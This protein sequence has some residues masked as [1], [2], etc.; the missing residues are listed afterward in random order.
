MVTDGILVV[1]K[2][3]GPTSQQVVGR[4]RRLAGTRKVGHAGTLDPMASGVLVVGIGRATR[5]LGHL[6]RTDKE[7]RATIR[8]GQA[9]STDDAEGEV[10]AAP[11]S[12]VLVADQVA[13]AL[14]DF[15][16]EISQVPSSVSAIKVGGVRAYARA[17]AGEE[18]TLAARTVTVHS[19]TLLSA[20][21]ERLDG[22]DLL[23]VDV[24]VACTSGTYIRALARDLGERFGVGAHLTALR[25]TRVGAFDLSRACLLDPAPDPLPVLGL[26]EVAAGSFERLDLTAAEA[27]EV[28]HGRRLERTIAGQVAV[29]S[30]EGQFLA[31]YRPSDRGAVAEAVFR[32]A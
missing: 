11:G 17:R 5:L 29:F 18:V 4:V 16:G 14:P 7:Y 6:M 24:D 2:T 32:P 10:L 28:R 31:L 13:A 9:T 27:T 8:F 25:R 19:F 20:R 21:T 3:V 15:T 1:D 23:D 12:G 26:D 22:L 30:P